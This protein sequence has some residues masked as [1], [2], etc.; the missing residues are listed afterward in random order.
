MD[1]FG[2]VIFL[3]LVQTRMDDYETELKQQV[4]LLLLRQEHEEIGRSKFTWLAPYHTNL[5]N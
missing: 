3:P 1:Q 4:L 5:M 2:C